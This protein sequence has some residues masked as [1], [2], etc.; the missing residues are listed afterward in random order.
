MTPLKWRGR[1][2]L[3]LLGEEIE[4]EEGSVAAALE[5]LVP[6]RLN[7]VSSR[8]CC[9]EEVSGASWN[10]VPEGENSINSFVHELVNHLSPSLM[11]AEGSSSV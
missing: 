7:R 4:G 9:G 10:V 1:T 6:S 8:G 2:S 11:A 5:S 3:G